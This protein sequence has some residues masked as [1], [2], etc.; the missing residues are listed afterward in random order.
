[1]AGVKITRDTV[2]AAKPGEKRLIIWDA[3][4]PGFGLMVQ[5]SGAMSWVCQYRA[6]KGRGAPTRRIVIGDP[7]RL[8]P[9]DARK[10]ARAQLA[11]AALGED[12]AGKARE[13]REALTVSDVADRFLKEHVAGKRKASTAAFYET[14]LN[15]HIRPAVGKRKARD[16][17]RPI[18]ARVH[19]A[20]AQKK[21]VKAGDREVKRG[22]PFVANR[23]LAVLAAMLAWAEK[24]EIVAFPDGL[25]TKGIE[26]FS[27]DA[28]ERFLTPEELERL[29]AA[30]AEA[31]TT[32][33]SYEIDEAGP[34]ARHAPAPENRRTIYSKHVTGALR[35]LL[36]TGCRLREALNLEWSHVDLSRGLVF[37]PDS[38]TG[39]KTLV[40]AAPALTVLAE[41]PR[42]GRY[43][44]SGETA[45]T[46]DEVPRADLKK[47][48][49]RLCK[50]AELEGV[51][52]HDLR[53]SFASFAAGSNIGL[54]VIGKLLGHTQASTTNRYAHL[55]A[56]PLK[57]AA[58]ITA[59]QIEAAL[60]GRHGA[61]VIPINRKIPK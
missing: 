17:T 43:V 44:F 12:P 50:H 22:G 8:D 41:M 54:P 25:P 57:R 20:I 46:K 59:N 52:L 15:T 34:K 60:E 7:S 36:F 30:L 3:V 51:R 26:P 49:A 11:R 13:D 48:W 58:D 21:A 42:I 24:Q 28:R 47:P 35:F 39:R 14:V 61:D 5:P 2:A 55:A 10:A 40:L 16:L 19:S 56:D 9:V 37:L 29:G 31:E 33:L 6:G 38:K 4:V 18:V 32:G 23:A 45:G 1:M 27:E 53:H